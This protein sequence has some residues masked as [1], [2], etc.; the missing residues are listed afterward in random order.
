MSYIAFYRKYRPKFFKNVVGQK[1]IIQT[2][3]NAIIYKKLSHCYLFSGNKGTG[4]TTLA[5]IFSKTINCLNNKDG[6]CCGY[7]EACNII[8]KQNSDIIEIDGASYNGVEEIRDLK[9]KINY[10]TNFL[11][12]KIYI[13]DEVH[14]LTGNA[15]NALLK[16]LEEPPKHVIFIFATTESHKIPETILSRTQHFHLLN[17]QKQHIIEKLT[18]IVDLEKISI[19]KEALEKIAFYSQGSLRDALN[20]LDQISSYETDLITVTCVQEIKG[21]VEESNLI[22]LLQYTFNKDLNSIISLLDKINNEGKNILI[23]FNDLIIIL[24]NC[25]LEELLS[26][27]DKKIKLENFSLELANYVLKTLIDY[28]QNLKNSDLKES[29]LE[30]I[31]IQMLSSKIFKNHENKVFLNYKQN[32]EISQQL[33]Y[34]KEKYQKKIFDILFNSDESKKQLILNAWYKL[35]S[36][37]NN[38]LKK[39]ANFLFKGKLIAVGLNN[40]MLLVYEESEI[41]ENVK[42]KDIKKQILT[43]LNSK[44]NI[45]KDFVVIL[46]KNWKLYETYYLQHKN[47]I[48]LYSNKNLTKNKEN[49]L[50]KKININN[51]LILNKEKLPNNENL[52]KAENNLSNKYLHNEKKITDQNLPKNKSVLSLT[53]KL[54]DKDIIE[55]KEEMD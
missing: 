44:K 33:P 47:K 37:K 40:E 38:T 45:I 31:F 21:A 14:V 8:D 41:L 22:K 50:N 13:I 27:H 34:Q 28:Q 25:L 55:I 39:A 1:I 7:C 53:E 43:I 4:K 32:I 30:I 20:L 29:F 54:F 12:Y 15:F 52:N 42:Q 23:L 17:I 10:K 35:K 51:E 9:N 2:L 36:Y 3:R 49:L 46:Q 11:K 26:P 19:D 6:D 16:T 48:V 5:K 18:E 24:K